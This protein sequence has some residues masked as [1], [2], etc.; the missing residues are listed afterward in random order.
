LL[1]VD[2]DVQVL[3]SSGQAQRNRSDEKETDKLKL[4]VKKRERVSH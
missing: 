2:E 4:D 3:M 1:D